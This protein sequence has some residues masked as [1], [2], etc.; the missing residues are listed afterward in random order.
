MD[1][2]LNNT[3]M[4]LQNVLIIIR[5]TKNRLELTKEDLV[6]KQVSTEYVERLEKI[7]N[8]AWCKT[9]DLFLETKEVE[10]E[11]K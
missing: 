10:Q 9:V 4:T 7:I 6:K 2:T 11:K 5:D 1:K 8:E 3:I